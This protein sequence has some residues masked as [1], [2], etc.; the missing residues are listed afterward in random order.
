M[1][2]IRLRHEVMEK[3]IKNKKHVKEVVEELNEA[4]FDPE[5]FKKYEPE[6]KEKFNKVVLR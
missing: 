1:F 5:F 2:G 6:I 3:W 4:N